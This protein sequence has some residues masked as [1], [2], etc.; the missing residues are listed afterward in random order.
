MSGKLLNW[1]ESK[2]EPYKVPKVS[3]EVE[4]PTW[5]VVDEEHADRIRNIHKQEGFGF[6]RIFFPLPYYLYRVCRLKDVEST[7]LLIGLRY[8]ENRSIEQVPELE[9]PEGLDFNTQQPVRVYSSYPFDEMVE[10]EISPFTA[11]FESRDGNSRRFQTHDLGYLLWQIAKAYEE[12]YKDH[13]Q[14]VG[15]WGHQFSDLAFGYIDLVDGNMILLNL[16]S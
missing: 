12:I 7:Q 14:T 2:G 16:E 5:R 8:N 6:Y 9:F 10:I 1:E 13:W 4:K 11:F 3:F 15:V